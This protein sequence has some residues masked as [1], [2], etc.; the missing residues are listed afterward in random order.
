MFRPFRRSSS[1]LTWNPVNE[2]CV[3]VGIRTVLTESGNVTYLTIELH[4]IEFNISKF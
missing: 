1:A 3:Y 2:C 4:K